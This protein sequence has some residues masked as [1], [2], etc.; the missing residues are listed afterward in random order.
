MFSLYFAFIRWLFRAI[1]ITVAVVVVLSLLLAFAQRA[2]ADTD[3]STWNGT[4]WVYPGQAPVTD[5]LGSTL[6]FESLNWYRL[7]VFHGPVPCDDGK[8]LLTSTAPKLGTTSETGTMTDIA[9]TG[10]PCA[11]VISSDMEMLPYQQVRDRDAVTYHWAVQTLACVWLH[12][13]GHALG[14]SHSDDGG[15]L[16]LETAYDVPM[17]ASLANQL[18]KVQF[19]KYHH[20]KHEQRPRV[21][22]R[23]FSN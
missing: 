1:L 19:P 14:K 16:D 11:I 3:L 22:R 21:K 17:C 6:K 7:H 18:T 4:A 13:I 10:Q 23:R 20:Q 12:E 8:T 2:F 9:G 5:S 15:P